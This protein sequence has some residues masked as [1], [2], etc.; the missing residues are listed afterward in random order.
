MTALEITDW[1]KKEFLGRYPSTQ[2]EEAMLNDW[3]RALTPLSYSVATEAIRSLANESALRPPV[4]KFKTKAYEVAQSKGVAVKKGSELTY[5]K[6]IFVQL[7]D[8]K[9]CQFTKTAG[10][11]RS[12]VI[13]EQDKDNRGLVERLAELV[14]SSARRYYGGT[15]QVISFFDEPEIKSPLIWMFDSKQKYEKK[16]AVGRS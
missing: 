1:I 9:G 8:A 11:F 6:K 15:W 5:S 10:Q 4:G 13:N 7:V 3:K 16:L 2:L 12:V 14:A